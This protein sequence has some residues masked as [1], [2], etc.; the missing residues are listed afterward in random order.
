MNLSGIDL[1][2]FLV[3]HAVLETGSVTDA[4]AQLHVTQSAVSNALARLRDVLGDPL[5]VRSG[6]GLV[7]TPRCEELRPLVAGAVAQLQRA[8][9]GQRFNPEEDTRVFTLSCGD[10]QDVC[11]VPLVVEAFARR[12]PRAF[13][14]V[15]SIDYLVASNGLATGD[16]DVALAPRA[17]AERDGYLAEDLYLERTVFLVRRDHPRI[18]GN[19]LTREAFNTE[20][21]VDMLINSGRPGVGHRMFEQFCKANGLS[22]KPAL[23]VS[24]FVAAGMAVTR[25]D[26]VAGMPARTAD[27]LCAMLPLRRLQFVP[28]P[29]AIPMSL[30]WHPR[31]STDP[32][33]RYFRELIVDVLR[34]GSVAKAEVRAKP[35]PQ[36]ARTRKR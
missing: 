29:A 27:V 7:A 18:T 35:R 9:D 6:R 16:V 1:N 36:A 12:L 8:V 31:T 23:A 22:F 25:S 15:V 5:L 3:L 4:A 21:H 30:I 19:T 33:A 2:L 10:N 34:D 13:L 24:H 11:D 32:A 17:V 26:L 20:K 28:D 14:R